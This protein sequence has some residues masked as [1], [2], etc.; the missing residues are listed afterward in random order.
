M[1]VTAG[2]SEQ[3]STQNRSPKQ[4]TI[5]KPTTI[6]T[7]KADETAEVAQTQQQ[8]NNDM[9]TQQ[10]SRPTKRP[11]LDSL[12]RDETPTSTN[13]ERSEPSKRRKKTADDTNTRPSM[14]KVKEVI[15]QRHLPNNTKQY[16]ARM[17]DYPESADAWCTEDDLQQGTSKHPA[18]TQFLASQRAERVNR[19]QT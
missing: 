10:N 2:Q 11:A 5:S 14:E 12:D 1:E 13:Q 19:H 8:T 3:T 6:T 18:L 15:Q 17:N 7:K 16:L 4:L 9:D